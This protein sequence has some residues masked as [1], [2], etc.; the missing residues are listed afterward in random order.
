MLY[1]QQINT[2]WPKSQRGAKFAA[3]RNALPEVLP[4]DKHVHFE[5]TEDKPLYK[6]AKHCSFVKTGDTLT[7]NWHEEAG[8]WAKKLVVLQ[9][10]QWVQLVIWSRY[11]EERTWIF[12]KNVLNIFWGDNSN[13]P[14]NYFSSAPPVKRIRMDLDGENLVL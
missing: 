13:I 14:L 2:T 4:A 12:Q 11:P 8:S 9:P 6:L 3:I 1:I 7:I 10:Q 5:L